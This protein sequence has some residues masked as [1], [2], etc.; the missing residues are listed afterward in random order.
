[1]KNLISP[2]IKDAILNL[3]F[4]LL[5]EGD[6]MVDTT[7]EESFEHLIEGEQLIQILN[8]FKRRGLIEL[9]RADDAAINY[10]LTAEAD[11][12]VQRGGFFGHEVLFQKSVEDLLTEVEKA[13]PLIPEQLEQLTAFSASLATLLEVLKSFRGM[14]G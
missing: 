1:M 8:H 9:G 14:E 4:E 7:Y 13:K 5:E 12:F 6:R 2:G 3:S 11:E 10:T